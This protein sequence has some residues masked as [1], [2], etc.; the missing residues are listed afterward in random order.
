MR[1]MHEI[2]SVQA[3]APAAGSREKAPQPRR[4]TLRRPMRLHVRYATCAVVAG[5]LRFYPD[6]Y[7]RDEELRQQLFDPAPGEVPVRRPVRG[8]GFAPAG[9]VLVAKAHTAA[10]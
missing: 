4:F 1:D 3:R 5:Q 9:K 8:P 2:D 7:K 6:V 10:P